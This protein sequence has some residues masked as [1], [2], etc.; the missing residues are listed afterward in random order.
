K[1]LHAAMFPRKQSKLGALYVVH[2]WASKHPSEKHLHAHAIVPNVAYNPGDPEGKQ[3]HRFKP[4]IDADLAKKVWRQALI[5]VGLWDASDPTLPDVHLDY[6]R[7]S[8]LDKDRARLVHHL[9]YIFRLPLADLNE[10]LTQGDAERLDLDERFA[11]FLLHYTTRRRRLGFMTNL[12]RFSFVCRKSSRPRCPVC[13][14]ELLK[15]GTIRS[16]L[17]R[18]PHYFRA[19]SGEWTTIPPPFEPFPDQAADIVPSRQPTAC[20]PPTLPGHPCVR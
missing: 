2:P 12:K 6:V 7:L 18:V 20:P 17:P 8:P 5:R 14:E 4:F 1:G 3:F 11:K 16:N 19:R 10:H 15:I 13:G 9:K